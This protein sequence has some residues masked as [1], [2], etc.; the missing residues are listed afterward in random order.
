MPEILAQA[1]ALEGLGLVLVAAFVAGCVRGFAGFG[2]AMIFLPVVALAVPPVWTITILIVMDI[3]GPL[4]A[5]PKALRDGHPRDLVR[6]LTGLIVAL[7]LGFAVLFAASPDFF[8]GAV[9]GISLILLGLLM[10]GVRYRGAMGPGLVRGTGALAGFLGG[11]A[12][13][14]GPPV[15]LLYMASPLPAQAI[16][17][18]LT[19]FLFFFDLISLAGF[20]V[21]GRLEAMPVVLGLV[22]ILPNLAGNL[23]GGWIFRP[24]YERLYRGVAYAVIAASALRGLA[25]VVA[26]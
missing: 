4:P 3:F 11:A 23:I 25:G 17:A 8:R 14:P 22:C 10:A 5:I 24:G 7:P 9:S 6:L 1:L 13:I 21:S 15:I 12:G 18:N 26:G 16:R 19:A 20:A 2:T